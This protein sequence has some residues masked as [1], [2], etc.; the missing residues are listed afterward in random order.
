MTIKMWHVPFVIHPVFGI[1]VVPDKI[2]RPIEDR[3]TFKYRY[4][5]RSHSYPPPFRP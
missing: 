4:T 5:N 2:T 1:W 3:Y